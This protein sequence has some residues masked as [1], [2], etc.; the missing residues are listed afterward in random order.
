[1]KTHDKIWR[2]FATKTSILVIFLQLREDTEYFPGDGI[3][4]YVVHFSSAIPAQGLRAQSEFA[5][6]KKIP[7]L[8]VGGEM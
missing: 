8:H 3:M 7:S 4:E 6:L 2:D 5:F 1:M